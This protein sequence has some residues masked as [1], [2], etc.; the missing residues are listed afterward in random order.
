MIDASA[1]GAH[2]PGLSSGAEAPGGAVGGHRLHGPAG[3]AGRVA[4]SGSPLGGM[5]QGSAGRARHDP[6]RLTHASDDRVRRRTASGSCPLATSAIVTSSS[7]AR[8]LALVATHT[9]RRDSAG[10][11]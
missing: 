2:P 7:T 3:R 6:G 4:G 10:P 11:G 5:P 8:R 1:E 9:S